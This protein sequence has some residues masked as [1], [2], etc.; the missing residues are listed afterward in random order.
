MGETLTE[1][2][3]RISRYTCKQSERFFRRQGLPHL[4]AGHS[5]GRDVFGRSAG[6]LVA[7]ML[8]ESAGLIDETWPW[9]LNLI[10]VIGTLAS[11]VGLY[12]LLN[13][14]RG[15][16][17]S[18]LP[19]RVGWPEL[20][21]FVLAPALASYATIGEWQVAV[22]IVVF[23]LLVLATTRV[24]VGLGVLSS[25]GWGI[26][27]LA[28]EFGT[29]LRR[30]IRLLPLVLIFSIVL[31]FNTEVWQVFDKISG[32]G[33]I[34][35]AAFFLVIIVAL[36]TAGARREAD[37]A[38]AE[39]AHHASPRSTQ[40]NKS[41]NRNIVAM[42]ASSQLLQVLVV[43]LATGV[44]FVLVGALTI[45]DG[46]R[47][48]WA[49]DGGKWVWDLNFLGTRLRIDQSLVR[50]AVALATFNG[51]YYA[52]NVQVDAVYRT[53]LVDD[54]AAQLNEV[55]QVREHYLGLIDKADEAASTAEA[56]STTAADPSRA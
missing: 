17:W 53:D 7:V 30:L 19:Q 29:S 1:Q 14:V 54:I 36:T 46:V 40:F 15:R 3:E 10:A 21:F 13:L 42:V 28:G 49:I 8:L 35:L 18:T 37:A 34:T 20:T 41:Q 27:R 39:A 9:W 6:F 31:F 2:T 51:L 25:L 26:A 24:V 22:A 38:I 16:G 56:A 11:I 48:A 45:T 32:Q 5:I 47:E 55:V 33:D 43:S 52:I 12:I 44:F 4:I 23:N 50:V